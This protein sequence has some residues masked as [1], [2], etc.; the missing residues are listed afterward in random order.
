MS[1]VIPF[2]LKN[3]VAYSYVVHEKPALLILT[4]MR[5]V[6]KI[7]IQQLDLWFFL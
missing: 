7:V 5:R 2:Q 1:I 3:P 4:H 6:L